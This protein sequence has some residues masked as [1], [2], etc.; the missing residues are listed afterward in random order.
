M[1]YFQVLTKSTKIIPVMIMGKFVSRKKYEY[2]EYVT[3]L[4]ISLGMAFFLYGTTESRPGGTVTTSSG[5]ILLM[6][7]MIS[8]SFTS[9]WQSALFSQFHMS[10]LQMMCGVNFFSSLFTAVSLAQQGGFV[11]SINFMAQVC[12]GSIFC[13]WFM[14]W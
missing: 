3:A 1:I 2:Y 7:Y 4:F 14:D 11:H 9:N 6:A 12:T 13:Q 8:D 10:S 5:M